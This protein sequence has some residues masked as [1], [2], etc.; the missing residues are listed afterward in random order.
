MSIFS[1]III[2]YL[3]VQVN[4]VY[5][6]GCSVSIFLFTIF[7]VCLSSVNAETA[8]LAFYSGI[9][10][11]NGVCESLRLIVRGLFE[12]CSTVI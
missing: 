2:S 1:L 8:N 10:I 7:S 3:T 5:C 6:F 11:L 4:K 12:C 9:I